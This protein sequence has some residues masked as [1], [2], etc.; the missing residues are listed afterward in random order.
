MR[1]TLDIVV[2]VILARKAG[3]S[4]QAIAQRNELSVKGVYNIC[5]GKTV[6]S[7]CALHVWYDGVPRSKFRTLI[8]AEMS[9][10]NAQIN[11][12]RYA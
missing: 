4:Y 11:Q 6:A 7:A 10:R 8:D 12:T 3:D 9:A 5:T 1:N 2:I